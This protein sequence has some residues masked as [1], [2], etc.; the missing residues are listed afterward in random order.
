MSNRLSSYYFNNGQ[1]KIKRNLM[2]RRKLNVSYWR[3]LVLLHRL[4]KSQVKLHIKK[5]LR[6]SLFYT[7]NFV[8]NKPLLGT[9]V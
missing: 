5:T 2:K 1:Y 9:T 7:Y 4:F 8:Q 6:E 3:F